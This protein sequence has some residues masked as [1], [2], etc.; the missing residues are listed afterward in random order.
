LPGDTGLYAGRAS[1]HNTARL[2]AP[3]CRQNRA[4]Q[5]SVLASLVKDDPFSARSADVK[6]LMLSATLLASLLIVF[7]LICSVLAQNPQQP[8]SSSANVLHFKIAV[9]DM[10]KVFDSYG[11]FKSETERMNKTVAAAETSLK[12]EHQSILKLQEEL[13]T[14][15]PG[16]PAYKQLDERIAGE[17]ATFKLK[18]DRQRKEIQ[19]KT[20]DR[21]HRAY[22][23]IEA[24][25]KDY[26]RT[27]QLGL[28]LKYRSEVVDPSKPKLPGDVKRDLANPII[29]QNS[30]DITNDV[31]AMLN[32]GAAVARK[33]TGN[34]AGSR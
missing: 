31:I 26:A 12:Q 33:P 22:T 6:K 4:A 29:F 10:G 17:K 20:T 1:R 27:K 5:G 28:V 30:I 32:R 9:I 19:S 14:Y 7:P 13:G 8:A 34:A 3:A 23:D 15:N 24:A 25:V 16:T 21:V 18:M 11:W 2:S